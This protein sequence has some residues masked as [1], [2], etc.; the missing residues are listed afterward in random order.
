M[1]MFMR[2]NRKYVASTRESLLSTKHVLCPCLYKFM[3]SAYDDYDFGIST[4]CI[5]SVVLRNNTI[6]T[7]GLMCT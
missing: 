5:V 1:Y 6:C 7:L 2:F 3:T 4:Y